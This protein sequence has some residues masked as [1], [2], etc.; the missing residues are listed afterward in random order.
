MSNLFT[1]ITIYKIV[2][3]I[4]NKKYRF[5]QIRFI[6]DKISKNLWNDVWMLKTL[7]VVVVPIGCGSF[8]AGLVF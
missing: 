5:Y 6:N 3:N 1:L 4:I 2:N 7:F 8:V